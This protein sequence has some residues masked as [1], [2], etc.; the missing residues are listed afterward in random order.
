MVC[1]LLLIFSTSVFADAP[2]ATQPTGIE[3]LAGDAAKAAIVDDSLDPY[4]SR[5]EDHE[6]SAKTSSPIT[7][8]THDAKI[9]EC[10]KRYQAAVLDFTEDDKAVLTFFVSKIQGPLKR[11]YP[12]FGNTPWSFVKINDTLEGGMAHTRGSHVILPEGILKRFALFKSRMGDKAIPLGASLLI[13]EQT[14]VMERLHPE[15]FTPLFTD[16]FHFIR[17]KKIEPNPWLT[18]RQLINPD[19]TVCD[20]IFPL[21]EDGKQTFVL[22]LIAFKEPNPTDL[23]HGIDMIAVTVEPTKEGYKAVLGTDGNP[24]VRPLREVEAYASGPGSEPNNY[25]PN[26]IIADRF[27]E[28]VMMDDLVDAATRKRINGGDDKK[29]EDRIKP[30]REWAKP[31]FAEPLKK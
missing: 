31:A 20:W 16:T 30:I 13:H 5:L 1:L 27:A 15:L 10:K 12:V 4:F 11:D 22:P 14:H 17:A 7:G 3:F 19:G 9:A 8:D 25:H 21:T 24:V 23:R 2:P 26:E 6:M 28:L 29:T 18:D